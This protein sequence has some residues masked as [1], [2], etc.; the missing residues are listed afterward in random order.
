MSEKIRA[1]WLVD[2][3]IAK[4]RKAMRDRIAE[5][6]VE[7]RRL[8]KLRDHYEMREVFSSAPA[9]LEQGHEG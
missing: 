8:M 9:A 4:N 5:Y 2:Q 3:A 1:I 6:K 7:E